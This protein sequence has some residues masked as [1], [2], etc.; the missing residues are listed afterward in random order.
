VRCLGT[1]LVNLETH[2]VIDLL[3]DR[4]T[5]TFATW[6]RTQATGATGTGQAAA[7]GRQGPNGGGSPFQNGAES[8]FR[9]LD[10]ELGGQI[11]W[12]LPLACI[13]L[14][15]GVWRAGRPGFDR[16]QFRLTL[17]SR[18]QSLVVWGV[19]LVAQVAFFSVANFFH[20]YH[21]VMLAPAVAA[22][23]GIGAIVLWQSYRQGGWRAWLQPI[24]LVV[25]A[26][27][28]VHLLAPYPDWRRWLAP[29]ILGL[30]AA[31]IV[32]L[33]LVHLRWRR[34]VMVAFGAGLLGLGGLLA[35]PTTWAAYTVQHGVGGTLPQAGPSAQNADGGP[36]GQPG[37]FP[38]GMP[39]G[40]P[41][42]MSPLGG[43]GQTSPG[44]TNS[45][46]V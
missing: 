19:W 25:V 11:G 16:R 5:D 27:V 38:A 28:Q 31:A 30:T 32:A 42:Q 46:A 1:I 24:A 4:T 7:A 37:V 10:T 39:G 43:S 18:W 33:A 41:G 29:T 34:V 36:G 13:G 40:M 21:L 15:V 3:P 2:T 6:L 17:D 26:A 14:L 12:L 22:F 23:S 8:P 20:P 35:A 9:L 45:S 44:G